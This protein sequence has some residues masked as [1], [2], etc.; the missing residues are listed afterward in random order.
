[1]TV[2]AGNTGHL[3]PGNMPFH[4]PDCAVA[5]LPGLFTRIQRA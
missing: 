2:L 1:M 5:L 4:P 3:Q